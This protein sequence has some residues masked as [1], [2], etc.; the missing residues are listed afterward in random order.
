MFYMFH[1]NYSNTLSLDKYSTVF[2]IELIKLGDAPKKCQIGNSLFTMQFLVNEDIQ[3]KEEEFTLPS[4]SIPSASL[5]R[6]T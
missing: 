6:D 5:G 3:M 2:T 4:I 1:I